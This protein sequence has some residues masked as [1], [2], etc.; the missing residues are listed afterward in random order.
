MEQSANAEKANYDVIWRDTPTRRNSSPGKDFAPFFFDGFKGEIRAGQTLIDFGCGTALV[1]KE[2]LSK[3]LNIRLVDISPYALDQEIR[4]LLALFSA[5]VQ[6]VQ[7]CLWQLPESL[8]SAYWIYCCDVLENIP[9]ESIEPV[10]EG[11]AARMR[12]GGYF[13]IRLK[14]DIA[15]SRRAVKEKRWWEHKLSKYFTIVG[16]D[17]TIDDSY[18]NCRVRAKLNRC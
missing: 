12:F 7:G 1:A 15:S 8:K 14:E 16:E 17:A 4:N 11:I 18:F 13:S 3:G 9:E 5:Q 6:F 2:F 10:L